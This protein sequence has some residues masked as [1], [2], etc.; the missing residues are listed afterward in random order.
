MY[1]RGL[2]RIHFRASKLWTNSTPLEGNQLK[3][4]P[5]ASDAEKKK[6]RTVITFSQLSI[7]QSVML[8]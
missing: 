5:K 4:E 8:G 3:E 7:H 2:V 1:F 6:Q